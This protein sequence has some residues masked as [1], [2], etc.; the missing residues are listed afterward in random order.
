M[1]PDLKSRGSEGTTSHEQPMTGPFVLRT[2]LDNVPLSEDGDDEEVKINCVD[3]LGKN[4]PNS[5]LTASCSLLTD[6]LS[7][8]VIFTSAPL[9]LS[10]FISSRYPPTLPTS[11]ANLFSY[12]PQ[13]CALPM[14]RALLP[15][16]RSR[17]FSKSSC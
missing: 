13:D 4:Q 15:A 2:L 11:P 1:A 8:E 3:Y 12:S 5:V 9:P 7:Q 16:M 6:R 17:G 14:L 10:F